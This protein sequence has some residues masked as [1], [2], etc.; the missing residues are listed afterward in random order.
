[1]REG[2]ASPLKHLLLG[3]RLLFPSLPPI[4]IRERSNTNVILGN[5]FGIG[6]CWTCWNG[7]KY[8]S[9]FRLVELDPIT[10]T[11]MEVKYAK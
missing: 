1:M 4:I 3:G 7:Y 10:K 2:M 6:N 5:T 8:R 11:F 9:C